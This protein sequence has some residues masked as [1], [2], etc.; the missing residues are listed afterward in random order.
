MVLIGQ[1]Y[2]SCACVFL[3][4]LFR[5]TI[6][7]IFF[8]RVLLDP[9]SEILCSEECQTKKLLAC[10][11]MFAFLKAI[12]KFC[13]PKKEGL[14]LTLFH[15][16]RILSFVISP[17]VHLQKELKIPLLTPITNLIKFFLEISAA[18][19]TPASQEALKPV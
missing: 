19:N 17:F 13:T 12:F 6:G 1:L 4:G 8:D 5:S 14:F 10:C 11:K 16:H 7:Y 9:Y 3:I 18:A 2:R 15:C